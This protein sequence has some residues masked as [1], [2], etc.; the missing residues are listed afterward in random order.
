MFNSSKNSFRKHAR[1]KTRKRVRLVN[2][3]RGEIYAITCNI[4]ESGILIDKRGLQNKPMVGENWI[5]DFYSVN[6]LPRNA[7]VK[8]VRESEDGIGMLFD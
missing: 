7:H 2:S 5:A 8:V 4:S 1:N 3:G 6:G